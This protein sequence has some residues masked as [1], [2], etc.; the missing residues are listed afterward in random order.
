[1]SDQYR[2]ESWWQQLPNGG[3]AHFSAPLPPEDGAPAA[4][5]VDISG[6]PE[7]TPIDETGLTPVQRPPRG[8]VIT[9]SGIP[10]FPAT[11]QQRPDA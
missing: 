4:E 3:W 2:S 10:P 9:D 1:M 7:V 5:P 6:W 11:Y 8:V